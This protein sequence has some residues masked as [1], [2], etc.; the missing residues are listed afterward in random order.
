MSEDC[1][2]A[3]HF[4]CPPEHRA[5]SAN[6]DW[7]GRLT[8]SSQARCRSGLEEGEWRGGEAS[9]RV[10]GMVST[11]SQPCYCRPVRHT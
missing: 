10:C 11:V 6:R 1:S 7:R 4:T 2:I 3:A 5:E 8:C 9:E